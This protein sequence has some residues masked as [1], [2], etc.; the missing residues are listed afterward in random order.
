MEED[1]FERTPATSTPVKKSRQTET[2][3]PDISSVSGLSDRA[4]HSYSSYSSTGKP[5]KSQILQHRSVS[6]SSFS[7]KL[8]INNFSVLDTILL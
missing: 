8:N 6:E 7:S 4:S 5:K 2:F 1:T 3:S